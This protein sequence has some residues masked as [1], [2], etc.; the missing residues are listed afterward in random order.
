LQGFGLLWGCVLLISVILFKT[1]FF[2]KN[3][4]FL[5]LGA[6]SINIIYTN[7]MHYADYI[8]SEGIPAWSFKAGMGQNI[9]PFWLDPIATG[10]LF[11]FGK[12]NIAGSLVL[13]V[14]IEIFLAATFFYAFLQS[15]HLHKFASIIGALSYFCG[16]LIVCST[17]DLNKYPTEVYQAAF[18]LFAWNNGLGKA[19]GTF[20]L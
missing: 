2:T 17:W 12:E 8:K 16:Y 7:L 3:I 9:N 5:D 13:V 14:V 11:L 15:L 18:L 10:V 1:I 19:N 6:D 4:F 20:S